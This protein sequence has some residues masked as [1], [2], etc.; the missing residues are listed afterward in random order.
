MGKKKIIFFF[1]IV[2]VTVQHS[3]FFTRI[4]YKENAMDKSRY[5]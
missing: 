4:I 2:Y 1:V 5:Y 3:N